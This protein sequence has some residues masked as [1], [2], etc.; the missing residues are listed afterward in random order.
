MNEFQKWVVGILV[1]LFGV[2]LLASSAVTVR[3]ALRRDAP[4]VSYPG[5]V[6]EP[7]PLVVSGKGTVRAKPDIFTGTIRVTAEAD[8]ASAAQKKVHDKMKCILTKLTKMGV[9]EKDL[10]TSEYSLEPFTFRQ[11]TPTR[12]YEY[13][14]SG[15]KQWG[16][17]PAGRTVRR[18]RAVNVL[19][20]KFRQVDRAGNI[21]DGA[22]AA[23]E[24]GQRAVHNGGHPSIEAASE[25]A[26]RPSCPR[27]CESHR[28][29]CGRAR[30][31]SPAG[32]GDAL[33]LATAAP[34]QPQWQCS[35]HELYA[36]KLE[37]EHPTSL[38]VAPGSSGP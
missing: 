13:S 4:L 26:G 17:Y 25:S 24:G 28:P 32:V 20:L 3:A 27:T 6:G 37:P 10:H 22:I 29:Q 30:R 11:A 21:V 31:T 8:T 18:Y 1:G 5:S 9:E 12:S 33:R 34:L 2:V 19:S 36:T 16:S 38:W 14:R 35:G 7:T 23:G 15:V